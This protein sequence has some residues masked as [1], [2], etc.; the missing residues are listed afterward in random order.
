MERT[1]SMAVVE[2]YCVKCREK[3]EIKDPEEVTMKNGRPAMQGTCPVCGTKLF[4]MMSGAA[5]DGNS[6][7]PAEAP[8]TESK[9]A[10]AKKTAKR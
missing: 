4:R 8:S 7:T 2:A 9:G 1:T 5:R 6:A 3:R 10:K